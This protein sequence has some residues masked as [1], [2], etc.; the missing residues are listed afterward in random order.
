M[1]VVGEGERIGGWEKTREEEEGSGW[2][3]S[4]NR[5]GQGRWCYCQWGHGG[6]GG[7][8]GAGAALSAHSF[9]EWQHP[10][11]GGPDQGGGL[12]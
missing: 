12:H 3:H 4:E 1:L 2:R 7:R 11:K 8:F 5:Q 10:T 9:P 6:V